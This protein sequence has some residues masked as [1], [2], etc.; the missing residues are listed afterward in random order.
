[1]NKLKN[2]NNIYNHY[3]TFFKTVASKHNVASPLFE[4][5]V[6]F[7]ASTEIQIFYK[8]GSIPLSMVEDIEYFQKHFTPS[9]LRF[10]FGQSLLL[11]VPFSGEIKTLYLGVIVAAQNAKEDKIFGYL[12]G[13]SLGIEAYERSIEEGLQKDLLLQVTKKFH[14]AMNVAEVLE[15]VVGAIQKVYPDF[16][17]NLLLS[18]EWEVNEELPIKP[19][20]YGAKCGNRT[21]EHAY[22]TG[23]IQIDENSHMDGKTLFVPLRGKQ[24][25]YGVMEIQTFRNG[26]LSKYK[27]D[28]IQL[29][30]DTG[31]NALEN[32]ELYQ[33]SRNL[34]HD[35]QLINETTHQLNRNLRLSDTIHF[36]TNQIMQSFE[37]EEV[38]FVLFSGDGEPCV[39]DGS[40][41]FFSKTLFLDEIKRLIQRIQREKDAVYIGDTHLYEDVYLEKYRSALIIPMIQNSETIGAA[42]TL[43]SQ[44]YHFT[45]EDFKLLQSL[46]HHSTLA[47]TNSILHEELERLAITDHLT[48]LYSRSYLD[49]RIKKSMEEDKKGTFLLLDIDNFKLINDTYG[50]QIGDE[51]IIQIAN[52]MKGKVREEDIVARWGGE[53][54]AI[55][56][57][58]VDGDIGLSIAQRIVKVVPT[59]TKPKVTVSIGLAQWSAKDANASLKRLFNL[60]DEAL[61]EAKRSGKNGVVMKN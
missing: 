11:A 7:I 48:K 25:V 16:R 41:T 37:A 39:L 21:V 55:Y 56:L 32:A 44:M 28:F 47:F 33:Q 5:A 61:Y 34:I 9:T 51:V 14:M 15:E 12:E 57:P 6:F 29:L 31:G 43:H 10:E 60:A 20:I 38:G 40:T 8:V 58:K 18:Q 54:L 24:G 59:V 1:M 46:I 4:H 17:I 42:V 19:L 49:K 45:F 26:D 36:M 53:E 2:G 13:L 50:H 22:L 52:I 30:A 35:L 23:E 3:R 27:I